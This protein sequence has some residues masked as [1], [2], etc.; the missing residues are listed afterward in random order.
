MTPSL[1]AAQ[2]SMPRM[3]RW[4]N[5][6]LSRIGFLSY[7]DERKCALPVLRLSGKSDMK[8]ALLEV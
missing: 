8:N 7:W 4:E 1:S 2:P 5:K 3:E 6:Q